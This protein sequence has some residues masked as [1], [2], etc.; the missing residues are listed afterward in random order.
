MVMHLTVNDC[1]FVPVTISSISGE[2][3]LVPSNG[4]LQIINLT[5]NTTFIES[6]WDPASFSVISLIVNGLDNYQIIMPSNFWDQVPTFTLNTALIEIFKLPND[7]L[8][9]RV[10]YGA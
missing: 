5:E 9:G 3:S 8:R 7:Q 4:P 10:V 6:G 2:C 1:E